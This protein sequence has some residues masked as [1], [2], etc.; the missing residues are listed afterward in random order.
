MSVDVAGLILLIQSQVPARRRGDLHGVMHSRICLPQPPPRGD[1]AIGEQGDDD[2]GGDG[3][4]GKG[5]D[6]V[7]GVNSTAVAQLR[8]TGFGVEQTGEEDRPCGEGQQSADWGAGGVDDVGL[9]LPR[10]LVV[11]GQPSHASTQVYRAGN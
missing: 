6:V 5:D 1:Q 4:E 10:D 7:E 2:D 9:G 11:V 8:D 3:V